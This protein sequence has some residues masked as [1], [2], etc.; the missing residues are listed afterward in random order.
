MVIFNYLF[1]KILRLKIYNSSYWARLGVAI[2]QAFLILPIYIIVSRLIFGCNAFTSADNTLKIG[3]IIFGLSLLGFNYYYYSVDR[4]NKLRHR[5]KEK[6]VVG[7][8]KLLLM[9]MFLLL[10]I[11]QAGNILRLFFDIPQC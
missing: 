9:F 11:I 8:I 1:V 3:F 6:R 7:A 2:F 4:I 10:W 5:F